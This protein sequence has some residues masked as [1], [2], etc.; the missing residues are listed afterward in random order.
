MKLHE[1]ANFCEHY[2]TIFKYK[3]TQHAVVR[4]CNDVKTQNKLILVL[5][6][7]EK[8]QK[9]IVFHYIFTFKNE[10]LDFK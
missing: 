4:C 2:F 3:M 6:C 5:N 9:N 7:F 8:F 10:F 1:V